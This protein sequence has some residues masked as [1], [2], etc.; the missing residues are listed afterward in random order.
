MR[1]TRFQ[2]SIRWMMAA[3]AVAALV[4]GGSLEYARLGSL[5][6]EY[7]GRAINARRALNYASRSAGWT[8]ET[9]R[10][11]V[12]RIDEMER[13]SDGWFKIGRPTHPARARRQVAYWGPIVAKYERAARFPWLA[14]EPDPPRPE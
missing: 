13:A 1:L 5:G 9:W 4:I 8:E 6:R 12:R 11:E 7:V 14:V 3:V 2:V 10:A